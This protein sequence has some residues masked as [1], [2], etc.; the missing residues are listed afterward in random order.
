[1]AAI[2]KPCSRRIAALIAALAIVAGET[3]SAQTCVI[4][5][6][7]NLQTIDG[8]GFC[9]TWSPVM[10]GA[11]AATLFGTGSGQL[12]FSLLRVYIDEAGDF[13][14]DAA[15]AAIAHSYGAKVLGTAW[16]PPPPM[17]DN[18]SS[19]GGSLMPSQ[20][21][22][23]ASY[24]A[25]A[26]GAIGLDF[27][28]FQNEPDITVTYQS[29]SWTP[30]QMETWCDDNASA[31]GLPIVMPESYDFND[32]YSDPTLDD[33]V[34]V[35]RIAYVAG[36]LY[37][38]GNYVHTNAL[39]H[40]KH[41][42]MTEHYNDGQ[43]LG[44]ALVDAK[45]VS[46]CMNNLFSAY[47][48]WHAYHATLT[49]LDLINGST[50]LLNGSAI[51]Q[52]AHWI[53]PGMVRCAATYNP[54][55]GV[56]VTAYHQPGLVIVVVNLNG[57]AV[58]QSFA[59]QNAALTSLVPYQTGGPY[60]WQMTQLDPFS[61]L[62]N[63]FAYP[64]AANTVTTFVSY[65]GSAPVILHQPADEVVSP[66]SAFVL[67]VQVAGVGNTYQWY[68]NGTAVSGQTRASLS[69]GSAS[70]AD[71]GEYEAVVT[72]A[73]GSATTRTATIS[74]ESDACRLINLS[75][76]TQL[77]PGRSAILGFTIGGSGTEQVLI[78]AAGPALAKF[79]VTNPMP[80]PQLE[81]FQGSAVIAQNAE[82]SP[83]AIGNA[84]SR[85][86]AFAFAPGS[87]DAA[88]LTTL[89]AGYGYTVHSSS[90]AGGSGTVLV[91][92]YDA[93]TSPAA[94]RLTNLSALGT[95]S[96]SAANLTIG[97]VLSGAGN[98]NLLIRSD[99]PALP[100]FGVADA[101]PD[102]EATL[103]DDNSHPIEA[104][105]GWT[106]AASPSALAA[107]SAAVGAFAFA[108]G[109]RDSALLVPLAPSSYTVQVTSAGN[110]TGNAL[111]EI[112]Q[113]P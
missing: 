70:A 96:G 89:E 75:C 16:T 2:K 34:G 55:P 53:R 106:T 46:D 64:L 74:V 58:S 47:F 36:H 39:S 61:V 59:V 76:L 37:G 18:D 78:R 13:T 66:G 63:A 81:V 51:G 23:Y 94:S 88:I 112:Y 65:D 104:N 38:G 62:G 48:W 99:G 40:N 24:L 85:V 42:W 110:S 79:G 14:S 102:P 54:Q 22:A 50:P 86:G 84:F 77:A 57:N 73:V 15:N 4:D 82:W 12:G 41:V 103:F 68:K 56:Y 20:Y 21:G 31:V 91:E 28:S 67:S 100:A 19:V 108:P 7:T 92:V 5:A 1:M 35:N 44:T 71:S 25:S 26:A 27:V 9:T 101:L 60:G 3:A 49:D 97:F 107:T 111:A 80:D 87:H 90:V 43:D 95:V 32:A 98:R 83:L 6:G 93:D 10:T 30:A 33:P 113:A 105:D 11:Q 45:E 52:F 8:F 72:I 17:K 109:S 69:I 29:C